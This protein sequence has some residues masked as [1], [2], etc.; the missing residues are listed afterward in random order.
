MSWLLAPTAQPVL[1]GDFGY[2]SR[3]YAE[4]LSEYGDPLHLNGSGGWLLKRPIPNTA[5]FDSMGTYPMFFCRNWQA[6]PED[7]A[8]LP[9]DLASVTLVT[10]PAGNFSPA[11]LRRAFPDLL[12]PFKEHYLVNLSEDLDLAVN[13]HH[14]YYARRSRKQHQIGLHPLPVDLWEDW[15]RL[16]GELMIRHAISGVAA[17]SPEGFRRQLAMPEMLA[18]AARKD[19]EITGIQL[20][21]GHGDWVYHHLS[22]YSQTGYRTRVSYGLMWEALGFFKQQGF[23]FADLGAAAGNVRQKDGLSAFKSGWSNEKG[24]VYLGGRIVN[25]KLYRHLSGDAASP[26]FPA[27]RDPERH[28]G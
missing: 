20:W 25:R 1:G 14:R 22:A 2:L 12:R 26:F 11:L 13:S 21:L 10:P 24:T 8:A 17:F 19:G 3:A 6:L 28:N 15:N 16:Y 7:L 27:Y 5:F 23:A 4:S 18:F 9:E